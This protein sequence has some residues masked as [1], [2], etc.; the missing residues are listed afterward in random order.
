MIAEISR[1]ISLRVARMKQKAVEIENSKDNG[2][3]VET[4]ILEAEMT[5]TQALN[6][7]LNWEKIDGWTKNLQ[8]AIKA[9]NEMPSFDLGLDDVGFNRYRHIEC[10][11]VKTRGQ[12]FQQFT[13]KKRLMKKANK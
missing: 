6:D 8:D 5:L 9:A 10:S 7:P 1:L 13:R 11:G 4:D 3:A 12:I 2:V